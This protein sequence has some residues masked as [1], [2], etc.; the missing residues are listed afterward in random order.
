MKITLGL[1]RRYL[2]ETVLSEESMVPGRWYGGEDPDS[3]DLERMGDEIG[4]GETDDRMVG[5]DAGAGTTRSTEDGDFD[6]SDHLRS[7]EEKISLGNPPDETMEEEFYRELKSYFLQEEQEISKGFYTPFDMIRDHTGTDDLSAT[8]YRSPGRE[9]GSEGDPFRGNDP[10]AQL[11]FHPPKA[12]SDPTASPPAADGESGVSARL[13]PPIWQLSAGSDTSKV[14]GAN[15]KADTS[16]VES[17]D[18]SEETQGEDSGDGDREDSGS[19]EESSKGK[20]SSS[21][22]S[23]DRRD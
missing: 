9:A 18:G 11:G 13:A 5:D 22:R 12:Q 4:M 23:R 17:N 6:I 14:L 19:E 15:A 2:Y 3:S 16:S 8:W 7:D 10:Y 1:L 20:E 21:T